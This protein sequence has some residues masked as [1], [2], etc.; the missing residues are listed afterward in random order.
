[1][2]VKTLYFHKKPLFIPK[3]PFLIT[4]EE[5]IS[6]L[7]QF[8]LLGGINFTSEAVYSSRRN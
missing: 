7:R 4:S 1:M 2:E 6:L 5:L 8:I 3:I